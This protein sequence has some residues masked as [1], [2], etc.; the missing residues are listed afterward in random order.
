MCTTAL[1]GEALSVRNVSSSP[2]SKSTVTKTKKAQVGQVKEVKKAQSKNFSEH[3]KVVKRE[4]KGHEKTMKK[5]LKV[6]K[7][8][9]ATLT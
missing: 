5:D 8:R 3:K 6:L 4:S 9:K 1:G 2:H 7:K